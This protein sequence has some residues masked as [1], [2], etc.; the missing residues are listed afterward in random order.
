MESVLVWLK[1]LLESYAGQH[2][3]LVTVLTVVGSLRLFLKPV[4][5]IVQN[6]VYLTPKKSDDEFLNK[7]L[8]SKAYKAV[9]YVLDWFGSVK[10]PQKK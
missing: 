9:S 1:P 6:V 7:V 10:L 3:W 8:E 4:M 5:S 2:G